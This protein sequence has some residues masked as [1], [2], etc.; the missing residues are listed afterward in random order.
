M[1]I[2]ILVLLLFFSIQQI[3]A[4]DYFP[5]KYRSIFLGFGPRTLNT[6]PG[7]ITT[8]Y[9]DESPSM[10][11]LQTSVDVEDSYTRV[12]LQFGYKW[13]RYSG[14]SHS[15]LFDIA[16]G[17]NSGGLFSYS[18]GYNF[19]VEVNSTALLIRPAFYGGFGNYGFYIGEFENNS[20]Y[21]EING[22]IFTDKSLDVS[23]SSQVFIYGPEVDF[24]WMFNDFLD[25]F[26]NLNYDLKNTN[27]RPEVVFESLGG[28][29]TTTS[30]DIDGE[31]P[32][33]TYNNEKLTS[34]PYDISGLRLTVGVSY[35]WNYD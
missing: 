2:K 22:N 25:V 16:L 14:L 32:I 6:D 19:L 23:L 18:L 21:I 5:H 29:G 34:L 31:N 33:V 17:D 15:I 3:S 11:H 28:E 12:G 24:M 1:K 9:I 27:S 4:Q 26:V 8:S 13:G 20:G 35:V 10:D 7:T 30:V